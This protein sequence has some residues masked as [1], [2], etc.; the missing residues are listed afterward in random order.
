LIQQKA[1][2]NEQP[3]TVTKVGVFASYDLKQC[4][5]DEHLFL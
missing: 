3:D 2:E 5:A 1:V 4:K